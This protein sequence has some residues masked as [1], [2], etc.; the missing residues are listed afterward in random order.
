MQLAGGQIE[1]IMPSP[2]MSGSEIKMKKMKILQLK[3]L[4]TEEI[5]YVPRFKTADRTELIISQPWKHQ[6]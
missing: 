3:T 4:Y 5:G 6:R 1:K 2:M